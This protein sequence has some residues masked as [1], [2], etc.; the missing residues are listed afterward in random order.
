MSA[1]IL[2]ATGNVGPHV[3]AELVAAGQTPRVMVRDADHARAL[4]GGGVEVI[5]GDMTDA[6]D[7]Q[8]AAEGVDTVFL[9]SP[10][11]FAMADAQ[12]GVIRELRRSG[13]R[14]VKLSGTSSAITADGP[15]ACRQHWEIE[16]VLEESGQPYVILRPNSFMQVLVGR[17]LLPA[18]AAT[19]KV[20][21]ALGGSGISLIDARDVGAVAARVITDHAWDGQTLVL[22]GPRA[23][24]YPE[25]AQLVA[26][27]TGQDTEV[28]EITPADV[29][30]S[31]VARATE[32]WEADHF[33]EM[34]ELFRAGESEFVTDTVEQVLGRPARTFEAYLDEVL[35]PA[36]ANA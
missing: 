32:E 24:T 15:H 31:L 13:I 17:L 9:L 36:E 35:A 7:L 19:G 11:A 29:R 12:L 22:T 26:A 18:L 20:M 25:I 14:I 2:G 5:A 28:V 3:V 10:H 4:L 23:V 27:R 16:R 30:A 33:E 6:V 21:N 8:R 1:L 34:Y